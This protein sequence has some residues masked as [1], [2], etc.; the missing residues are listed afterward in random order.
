MKMD[1]VRVIVAIFLPPLAVAMQDG[2]GIHFLVN[3]A[4]WILIP[5]IGGLIHALWR[6]LRVDD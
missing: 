3:L 5:W 6:V 2:I 1:L 4:L